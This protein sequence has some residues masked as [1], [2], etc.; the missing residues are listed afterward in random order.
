MDGGTAASAPA[1]AEE[2]SPAASRTVAANASS[3]LP[4][5]AAPSPAS[6]SAVAK[7]RRPFASALV[8]A[9]L[10]LCSCLHR[11]GFLLPL[12]SVRSLPSLFSLGS[13]PASPPSLL[14]SLL[15]PFLLLQPTPATPLS[16]DA[17]PAEPGAPPWQYEVIMDAGSS[18]TRVHVYRYRFP[19]GG[20][21]PEV[22]PAEPTLKTEPGLSTL[23]PEQVSSRGGPPTSRDRW[24][25]RGGKGWR[26]YSWVCVSQ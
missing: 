9:A 20:V 4:R 24:G 1:F 3:A 18:G 15:R 6:H 26:C 19:E 2:R 23:V 12:P 11:A 17:A 22:A 7:A 8:A 21:L 10:I 14:A 5:R 13:P 25:V 16:N